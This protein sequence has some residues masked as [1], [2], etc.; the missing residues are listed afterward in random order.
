MFKA[1]FVGCAGMALM[2][3]LSLQAVAGQVDTPSA[4][5]RDSVES[6]DGVEPGKGFASREVLEAVPRF[7]PSQILVRM[8]PFVDRAAQDETL[9]A[10]GAGQTLRTIG[11][12]PG[13]RV[14]SVAP[15]TVEAVCAALNNQPGVRYAS[16]DYV[17]RAHAQS[18]PYG[19][20][21]VKADIAWAKYGK[22]G[23]AKVAVLDTGLDL[24]HPDLPATIA[25][26]S[27]VPGL[28]VDDYNQ[29][30]THCSGTVLGLDNTEGVIGVGPNA[31]LII[32]KVLNSGGYG[33]D[34]WIATAID[35][36]VLQGAD[37]ISMSLGEDVPDPALEDACLNAFNAGVLVVA[38]AG[39]AANSAPNYPASFPGVMSISAVDSDSQLASFSSFGPLVS[40]TAPGVGVLSTV[41]TV[42]STVT[43]SNV[44]RAA[45]N[46]SGSRGGS[47]TGQVV[48]CG[49]GG[50]SADFPP[51][52]AGRIAHVR[53]G[54]AI[55][56]QAKAQNAVDAGAIGVII[57]NN[58]GGTVP[59]DGNLNDHF[60]IPVFSI[61]QNDG[62]TLQALTLPTASFNQAITAHTYASLSG[63]SM[64]CPHTSGTAAV[65]IGLFKSVAQPAPLPPASLRWIME[66]TA[67][68][69]GAAGRDDFFGWGM[70]DV[71]AGADYL[72]GRAVCRGDLNADGFVDDSDFVTFV[73]FYNELVTPGGAWTGGDFNGDDS[74]DDADFVTFA[75]SY[76]ALICP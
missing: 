13:L 50:T 63:T 51:S 23:G 17:R 3:T 46:L 68:D 27:F 36:A 21:L 72:Y 33:V 29:H 56:F 19:I 73:G 31:S 52:V 60:A 67:V 41:P 16:P 4:I 76:D 7:H 69:L 65:L 48:Y 59:F 45:R 9:R 15:G 8:E 2:A 62:N 40:V 12:V 22:G 18:V 70:V 42:T 53:R 55:T 39:N 24:S 44:A 28:T 11:I 58:T 6:L 35:W 32:G 71:K 75:N 14:V 20:T 25:N 26:A 47:L 61:S 37:V 74:T 1:G 38:S 34:S 49:F 30:G 54:N 5:L 10:A 66:Q 43:F 57:S 64:S